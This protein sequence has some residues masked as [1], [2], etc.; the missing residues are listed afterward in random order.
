MVRRHQTWRHTRFV[1]NDQLTGHKISGHEIRC[2]QT[3]NLQI[4]YY[5]PS[6]GTFYA[7]E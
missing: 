6:E 2:H 1:L 3:A 4:L 5:E 7:L